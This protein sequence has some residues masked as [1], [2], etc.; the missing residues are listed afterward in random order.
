MKLKVAVVGIGYG[1]GIS[2]LLSNV[3]EVYAKKYKY[4]IL[5][6]FPWTRLRLISQKTVII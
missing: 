5:G 6:V 4:K 2:R 3:G 1:D